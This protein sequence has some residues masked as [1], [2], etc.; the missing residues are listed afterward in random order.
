[1][2]WTLVC[3]IHQTELH[4]GSKQASNIYLLTQVEGLAAP[5]GADV[6]LR[7]PD[8]R[9]GCCRLNI[10]ERISLLLIYQP[11][12]DGQLSW[13]VATC[14][15][16]PLAGAN[17]GSEKNTKVLLAGALHKWPEYGWSI[18]KSGRSIPKVTGQSGKGYF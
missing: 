12:E 9:L 5:D 6:D 3:S 13:L 2:K 1:M 17:F 18:K 7:H 15:R 8:L 14:R 10:L 11:W 4:A 16:S